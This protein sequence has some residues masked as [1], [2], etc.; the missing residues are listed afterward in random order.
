MSWIREKLLGIRRLLNEDG[1]PL[2]ERGTVKIIGATLADNAAGEYTEVTVASGA[3]TTRIIEAGAGL[4]GG[5]DL[6]ADRAFAVGANADGSIAVNANDIQVG[7]LA[8]DAQHGNRGG[9]GIHALVIA[10]GAAGFMSGTDK[11]K[12]DGATASI[13]N[14][15][16]LIRGASG[17]VTAKWLETDSGTGARATTGDVRCAKDG[18]AAAFRNDAGTADIPLAT[19]ETDAIAHG[20]I[21]TC[22]GHVFRVKAAAEHTFV[23][24]ANTLASIKNDGDKPT[25]FLW[26]IS[27]G[28]SI[29]RGG[30]DGLLRFQTS[31]TD[32]IS[33]GLGTIALFGAGGAGQLTVTQ[34]YI[35]TA[36]NVDAY[37]PDDESAAFT[38]IDNAQ[39]GTV[40]ATV[41]DLNALRVAVEN[42]RAALENRMKVLN[43]MIDHFQARGDFL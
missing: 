33:I 38:G 14:S 3:P 17:E 28:D 22:A 37:T 20:N 30:A 35:T 26:G 27:G 7:I 41:A 5:G 6:S 34:D 24:G 21:T 32:Y 1:D 31:T 43:T 23:E 42:A 12:L 16:I 36:T 4:A 8:T 29:V 9:G 19:C 2:P 25:L 39:V 18:I 40:Y 15:T 13:S 11:T 10:G